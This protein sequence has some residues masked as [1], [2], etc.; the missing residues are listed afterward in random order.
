MNLLERLICKICPEL[1]KRWKIVEK[2]IEN[3]IETTVQDSLVSRLTE[4]RDD[5]KKIRL[6]LHNTFQDLQKVR[7]ETYYMHED[8]KKIRSELH[9]THIQVGKSQTEIHDTHNDLGKVRAEL[10]ETCGDVKKVRLELHN[11]HKEVQSVRANQEKNLEV[12][13]RVIQRQGISGRNENELIWS[14]VFNNA[15]AESKWLINQTFCP[16]RW[17][18]GYPMLYILYRVLNEA[19]PRNILELGLGQTT[20]M[21]GQYAKWNKECHHLV[22][23]HDSSWIE[24]FCIDFVLS[25]NSQILQLELGR[26]EF[27]GEEVTV[28]QGFDAAI[29]G[30]YNLIVIDAPF[31]NDVNNYSR[32]DIVNTLP[33]CL[34]DDFVIIIDDCNRKGELNTK[35]EIE[36]ILSDNGISYAEGKYSGI[37]DTF[38]IVSEK[39]KFLCSL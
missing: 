15:I 20:R 4:N 34:E 21:I 1:T 31:G 7:N 38:V 17:A 9:D 8:I 3:Y 13:N 33:D 27:R 36:R 37:K 35:N 11:T 32:V 5:G 25:Q 28:Y 30:R 10:H 22:V 2:S 23:E 19:R 14:Q 12:V 39:L 6:E 16:G 24:F 29:N 26:K 18:A